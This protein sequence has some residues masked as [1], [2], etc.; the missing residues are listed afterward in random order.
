MNNIF[1]ILSALFIWK[2]GCGCLLAILIVLLMIAL[3]ILN[4]FFPFNDYIVIEDVK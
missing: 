3:F 4:Q 1:Q 2:Y